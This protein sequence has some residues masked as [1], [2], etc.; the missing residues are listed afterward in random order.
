MPEQPPT[1]QHK[2]RRKCDCT[3]THT[4]LFPSA[5][6]KPQLND[7]KKKKK[8]WLVTFDIGA[9]VVQRG[10]AKASV[11]SGCLLLP[12]LPGARG[13]AS[14]WSIADR[15]KSQHGL[16][17]LRART[18]SSQLLEIYT[19]IRW[20]DFRLMVSRALFRDLFWVSL[21]FL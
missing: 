19:W 15:W 5:T 20:F 14:V 1:P 10:S 18:E 7:I 16:H 2:Q 9:N 6:D 17:P 13:K 12:R 8:S 21:G 4:P 11:G 3:H